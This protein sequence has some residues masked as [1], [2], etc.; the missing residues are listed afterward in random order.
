MSGNV[1]C[2]FSQSSCFV[3]GLFVVGKKK[4]EIQEEDY[5]DDNPCARCF[6][7]VRPDSVSRI[8]FCLHLCKCGL[9][10][11]PSKLNFVITSSITSCM[12]FHMDLK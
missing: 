7:N 12:A 3:V 9:R 6:S 11:K 10:H 8:M 5:D 4:E 1:V 2:L